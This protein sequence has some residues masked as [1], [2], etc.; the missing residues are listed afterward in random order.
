MTEALYYDDSY[1]KEF[2]A[3]VT[4]VVGNGMVLATE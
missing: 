2:Q 4:E 1:L 3:V